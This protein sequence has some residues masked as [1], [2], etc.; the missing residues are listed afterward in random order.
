MKNILRTFG[1][2][3]LLG[4]LGATWVPAHA[5]QL[6]LSG[7]APYICAVVENGDTANGTPVITSSCS[8]A[9]A[10]QWSYSNGQLQGIGTA[11]G[12]SMCLDVKGNASAPGTP[13][14]LYACNGGSNQQWALVPGSA[15]GWISVPGNRIISYSDGN[16]NCLDSSGGPSAGGGTQ[17]VINPCSAAAS[18]NFTL[19]GLQF[20]VNGTAPY[21]CAAVEGNN[22]ANGTPVIAYTCNDSP[23]QL[24]D[25][26]N[27]QLYGI[28]TENGTSLCLAAGSPSSNGVSI[29]ELSTCSGSAYQQWEFDAP[30]SVC[31]GDPGCSVGAT[32]LTNEGNLPAVGTMQKPF[33]SGAQLYAGG[34]LLQTLDV[35]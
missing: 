33:G 15:P 34:Y 18:Q 6:Q 23:G 21:L 25:Y 2:A 19:R 5:A 16:I 26:E 9:P 10:A 22:A 3:L 20:Q 12:V 11:N 14:Q 24:W 7:N 8:G 29:L 30:F 32:Q 17:L 35:F 13:V 27:G 31:G 1:I 28:G 4:V